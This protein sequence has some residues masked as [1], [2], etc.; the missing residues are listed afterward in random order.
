MGFGSNG[1]SS[2]PFFAY[3]VE[4]VFWIPVHDLDLIFAW[5]KNKKHK[6]QKWTDNNKIII[7]ERNRKKTNIILIL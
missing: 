1:K 6:K 3:I 5:W 2:L 4:P 7:K